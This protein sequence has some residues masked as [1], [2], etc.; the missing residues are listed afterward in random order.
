M[1]GGFLLLRESRPSVFRLSP[2]LADVAVT[3]FLCAAAAVVAVCRRTGSGCR[4]GAVGVLL[5]VASSLFAAERWMLMCGGI[6]TAASRIK[7]R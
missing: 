1:C 3:V 7:L 2:G 6:I 5:C 4:D